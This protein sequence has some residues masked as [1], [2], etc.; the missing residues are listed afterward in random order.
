MNRAELLRELRAMV[1]DGNPS[2]AADLI[3]LEE[4]TGDDAKRTACLCGSMLFALCE[5]LVEDAE[6]AQDDGS[7]PE[8]LELLADDVLHLAKLCEGL[9]EELRRVVV[10]GAA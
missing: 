2:L 1:L 9:G 7:T 6:D 8:T 3:H 4:D 5:L 10:R